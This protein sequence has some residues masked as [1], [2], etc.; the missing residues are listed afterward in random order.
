MPDD[1]FNRTPA[2][3]TAPASGSRG[4]GVRGLMTAALLAFL[5]GAAGVG[6][7]A[8]AG[9]FP[10][11]QP[12]AARLVGAA[13]PQTSAPAAASVAAPAP[14]TSASLALPT[15]M[16]AIDTRVAALEQ[17]ISQLDLRAEAASGNAARAEGLLVA[18][19]ARR[20]LDKG[21]PLGFLED[22]LRLRFSDAQPNAVATVIDAARTPVTLDA[23]L[24]GLDG[25]A[26]KLAAAPASDNGLERFRFELSSLFVI[27]RSSAPSPSPT[28]RLERARASLLAGKIDAAIAEVQAMPGSSGAG[29]WLAAARRYA[30]ARNALDL[31]ETTALIGNSTLKDSAGQPVDQPGFTP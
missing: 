5:I 20:A 25:L 29:E 18:F 3:A 23:L 2:S 28:N 6:Y 10:F 24:A 22:Q 8:W 13:T 14:S 1:F 12:Q 19:A 4:I 17:R 7:V 26:P 15:S 9:L 11:N 31:I 21:A 30:Q 16:S 27:R